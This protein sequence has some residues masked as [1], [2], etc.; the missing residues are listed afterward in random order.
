[1]KEV[2]L[3]S[4]TDV[5]SDQRRAVGRPGA[6]RDRQRRARERARHVNAVAGSRR[7]L[8]HSI[9][10]PGQPGWVEEIDRA[11]AEWK[12]DSWKG[13]TVGDPLAPSKCPVAHGR[14]ESHVP[15]LGEDRRS[16]TAASS[17]CTRACCPRDYETSTPHWRYAMVDDVGQGREA[18][19]RSSRS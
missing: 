6:R 4:D 18:T 14:R 16:R 10:R 13:Y 7:M 9:L 5:G 2:F 12:P 19:G 8:S 1:M 3:D 11:L 17:A 15:R